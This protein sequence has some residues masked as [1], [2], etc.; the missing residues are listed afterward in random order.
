MKIFEVE[1]SIEARHTLFVV[2]PDAFEAE[3]QVRTWGRDHL[4]KLGFTHVSTGVTNTKEE[5]EWVSKLPQPDEKEMEWLAKGKMEAAVGCYR[6][7]T[8][9]CFE[10]AARLFLLYDKGVVPK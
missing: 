7:R 2:S 1:L 6:H 5:E 9:V 4:I 3:L 8:K 10:D